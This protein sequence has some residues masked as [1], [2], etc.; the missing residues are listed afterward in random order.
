MMDSVGSIFNRR[1]RKEFQVAGF[2][3]RNYPPTAVYCRS[4]RFQKMPLST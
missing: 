1:N 4:P 3:A 2:H